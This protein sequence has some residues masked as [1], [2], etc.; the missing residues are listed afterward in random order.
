MEYSLRPT[1]INLKKNSY[2][3]ETNIESSYEILDCSIG[4][5]PFGYCTEV[6]NALS[7][8]H[9]EMINS[10]PESNN[11]L[12]N[13][14]INFWQD[15][16]ELGDENILLG[17]G[18]IDILYKTNRLFLDNNSKVL[19]YS[20][21]FSDYIDDVTSYGSI[22]DY[23]LMSSENNYKFVP[24]AFLR[25]IQTTYKLI[26]LDNPNNPTGQIIS[27]SCIEEIVKQA[28]RKGL[29]V[30]IDEA[31]GDFMDK[32]N[33]AI[34]LIEKYN[35][36]F[37]L[38]TFSKGFGLAGLRGAYLVTSKTLSNYYRKITNPYSMNSIARYLAIIALK[39]SSF[40]EESK[41]KINDLKSNVINSLEG[42]AVLHTSSTVPIMTIKH[43][44][45]EVDLQK[46]LLK[47]NILS[48]SGSGFIGLSKNFVRLRI[49]QEVGYL[50]RS[51]A[52]VTNDL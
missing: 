39:N 25:K 1:I 41:K 36:I 19:G 6:K 35:N 15:L 26:Y 3:Q 33:S 29:C 49:P 9:H 47:H 27:I 16:I 40:I 18:S 14:I 52:A 37:V 30:I 22:Y 24:E 34:S 13:C 4:T 42:L 2:A 44:D 5:N 7:N 12:K 10:Y 31:Y 21:Q 17:D 51:L 38:R 45:P 11:K 46:E 23:E 8:I 20:P 28:R 32:R 48:V 43:P 50:S